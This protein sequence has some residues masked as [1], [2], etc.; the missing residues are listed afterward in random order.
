MIITSVRSNLAKGRIAVLS[1]LTA[2]NGFIRSWPHLIHGSL[3]SHESASKWHLNWFTCFCTAHRCDQQ[4]ERQ[5]M[6]QTDR[7]TDRHTDHAT[8]DICS[9]KLHLCTARMQYGL[10]IITTILRLFYSDSLHPSLELKNFVGA[11]FTAC[12]PLLTATRT[13]RLRKK[14]EFSSMVLST[15]FLY[16]K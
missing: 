16:H 10:I 9:N 2:A 15:L 5:T 13:S 3:D 11:K 8:R 14:L 4:T 6:W 7:Q 1:P 12:M